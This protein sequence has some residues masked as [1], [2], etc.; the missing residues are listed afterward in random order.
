MG[1]FT[2]WATRRLFKFLLKK[3][4]GRYVRGEVDL[5][6]LDVQLGSGL[7]QLND[8]ALDADYINTQV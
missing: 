6:Q 4:L 5:E 8:V 2:Q 1:L 7:A 3:R